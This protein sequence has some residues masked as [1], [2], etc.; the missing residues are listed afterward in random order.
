MVVTL[1]LPSHTLEAIQQV[2]TAPGTTSY[3]SH[4]T[5]PLTM[6]HLHLV[7]GLIQSSQDQPLPRQAIFHHLH[8]TALSA[9]V[10]SD[11][12]LKLSLDT[13]VHTLTPPRTEHVATPHHLHLHLNPHDRQPYLQHTCDGPDQKPY[14]LIITT[15]LP[16]PHSDSSTSRRR[17]MMRTTAYLPDLVITLTFPANTPQHQQSIMTLATHLLLTIPTITQRQSWNIIR[18]T[19]S[20][21]HTLQ[22]IL[23]TV[24]LNRHHAV[25]H[26]V[27]IEPP[28]THSATL[29]LK[30]KR[31]A[32]RT[33]PHP[34]RPP[35]RQRHTRS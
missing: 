14:T 25:W 28:A 24:T 9:L 22:L 35:K 5:L 13:T 12:T 1:A 33:P 18:E 6:T 27:M 16:I 15:S 19:T 7:H 21:R 31:Q 17:P 2:L 8:I 23:A 11:R 20:H 10:P 34:P 26:T 30:P 32:V 4:P 29:S 3:L